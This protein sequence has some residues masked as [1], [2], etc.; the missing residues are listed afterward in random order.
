MEESRIWDEEI[1]EE[2]FVSFNSH[3][4]FSLMNKNLSNY[5]IVTELLQT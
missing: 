4:L 5:Q 2:R 3:I 1:E